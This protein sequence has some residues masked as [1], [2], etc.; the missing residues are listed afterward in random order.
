MAAGNGALIW[1]VSVFLEQLYASCVCGLQQVGVFL[2]SAGGACFSHG[3]GCTF[4]TCSFGN[5]EVCC[6]LGELVGVSSSDRG[7]SG[8]GASDHGAF[9]RVF[10]FDCGEWVDDSASSCDDDLDGA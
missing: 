3:V 7:A 8:C 5:A 2:A 6:N 9:D 4:V 10:S 1:H